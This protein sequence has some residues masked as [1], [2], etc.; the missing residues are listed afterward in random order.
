MSGV[1]SAP[2]I[3]REK[4]TALV[5]TSIAAPN[6]A[7]RSLAQG[8]QRRGLRFV[9]VGDSKSPTNFELEG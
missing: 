8:A 7:L 3:P 6:A 9:L 4:P 1:E 2:V 5:V